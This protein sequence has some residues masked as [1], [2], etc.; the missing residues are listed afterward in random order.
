MASLPDFLQHNPISYIDLVDLDA[1]KAREKLVEGVKRGRAKPAHVA[2]PGS[3]PASTPLDHAAFPGPS[4]HTQQVPSPPNPSVTKQ[5][6]QGIQKIK[7]LFLAANP[8]STSR[9]ALDDEMRTI[10]QKVRAAEYR[11]ALVF[12]SSWAVRPDDLLQLLNQHRPHIVHFSGHGSS[13]GLSLAGEHG[14]ERLVTTQA[15]KALFGTLKD[16]IR[17]VL[18]NACYSREQAQAL[19]ETIDCVI[20]MKESIGDHA[21]TAFASSFYRAIGFGRSIQQAFDQGITSLLLEGISQEE[22]PELLVKDG[23]DARKVVLIAPATLEQTLQAIPPVAP[24]SASSQQQVQEPSP[25]S[26]AEESSR[27]KALTVFFSYAS[28]DERLVKELEKQLAILKRQK[29]IIRWLSRD[30]GAGEETEEEIVNHLNQARVILLL[31]SPD[32]LSSERLW[33]REV[34]LALQ[35][36]EAKEARVIPILL[37]PTD[38]WKEAPFGKLQALPRNEKAVTSWSNRDEAFAE[39]A[40]GIREAVEKLTSPNP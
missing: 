29:R 24:L 17:L 33:D 26:P 40:R 10:E 37:R 13:E 19:R 7:A 14:Q 31:L 9:L 22:I 18:L 30:I 38:D 2:F 3:P 20:G 32:F 6:D 27:Q 5:R 15:L 4:P 39:V 21:A 11:D 25:I 35:K 28:E 23:V 8:T 34:E 36:H 12:Q 16:N 1:Q